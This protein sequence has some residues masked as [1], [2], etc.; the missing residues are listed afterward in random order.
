MY[1]TIY[2]LILTFGCETKAKT[3]YRDELLKSIKDV[4][5]MEK[6]RNQAIKEINVKLKMDNIER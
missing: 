2:K 3:D 4:T 1:K 5:R 6:F